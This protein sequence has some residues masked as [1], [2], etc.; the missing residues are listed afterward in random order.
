M[1]RNIMRVCVAVAAAAALGAL[2]VTGASASGASGRA[3]EHVTALSVGASHAAA[4]PGAR[5]WVKR[6][7]GTDGGGGYSVAVS[8]SGST[9]FVTGWGN[10]GRTTIAYSS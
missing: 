4:I 5:L 7:L 8:P 10:T 9:V 1:P 2:G 6:Y 3:Q